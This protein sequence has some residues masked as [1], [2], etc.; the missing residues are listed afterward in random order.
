MVVSQELEARGWKRLYAAVRV[1][2]TPRIVNNVI[3]MREALT[4]SRISLSISAFIRSSGCM[5]GLPL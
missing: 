2:T 4:S 5:V 3:K 1:S